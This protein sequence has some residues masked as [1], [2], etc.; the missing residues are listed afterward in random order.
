M[1]LH[2]TE[3]LGAGI[4]AL[5]AASF[6]DSKFALLKPNSIQHFITYLLFLYALLQTLITLNYIHHTFQTHLLNLRFGELTRVLNESNLEDIRNNEMVPRRFP[7]SW[8]HL[9]RYGLAI[10]HFLVASSQP[11]IPSTSTILGWTG[12]LVSILDPGL[13]SWL[14]EQFKSILFPRSSPSHLDVFLIVLVLAIAAGA[15][16]I[17]L[18]NNMGKLALYHHWKGWED[19]KRYHELAV[20]AGASAASGAPQKTCSSQAL[21]GQSEDREVRTEESP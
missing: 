6:T 3:I 16:L 1:S 2:I 19:W 8:W 21:R 5:I 12:F 10:D 18:H 4:A 9:R 15:L 11:M 13:V 17:C 20:K 14:L 7:P